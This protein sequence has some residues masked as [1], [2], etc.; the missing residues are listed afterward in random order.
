MK[1]VIAVAIVGAAAFGLVSCSG[2][3][4]AGNS[5]ATNEVSAVDEAYPVDANL[6]DNGT[7]GIDASGGN[8]ADVTGLDG[9]ASNSADNANDLSTNAL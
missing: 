4:G 8:A 7:L 9:N 2:E 3:S 5:A 1:Q 6:S